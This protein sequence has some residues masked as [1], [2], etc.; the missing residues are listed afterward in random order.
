MYT[1]FSALPATSRVWVYQANRTLNEKELNII[2]DV[3][4]NFI[5]RWHSHGAELKASFKIAYQK[6]IILAVD[7]TTNLPSGCSID[8]SVAV[9]KEIENTI[10]IDL[11]DRVNIPFLEEDN[12]I[13]TINLKDIAQAV[14]SGKVQPQTITFNN[15]VD[16]KE[17]FENEWLVTAESSW[18]KRYFK[19]VTKTAN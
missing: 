1:Q 15:M 4:T 17:K 18:L 8:S 3:L 13:F 6:F 14:S 5:S 7:T 9:L 12:Q 11:F 19:K 16:N 10:K 2:E